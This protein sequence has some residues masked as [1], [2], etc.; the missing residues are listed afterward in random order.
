NEG[1]S[2]K[3]VDLNR[4]YPVDFGGS[5]SSSST[6]S[7]VYH[8]VAPFSEP[9]TQNINEFVKKHDN[10]KTM[11]SFHTYSELILYPWSYTY[12]P[13]GGLDEKVFAKM[14]KDMAEWN[15]YTPMQSSGLYTSSGDTC[16]WAY[17]EHEIFC[18]TFELNPSSA[19]EGGFYPGAE[20]IQ[21]AFQLNQK[22]VEYLLEYT[23]DPYRVLNRRR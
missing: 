21:K 2:C 22:P 23:D 3:G 13:I 9:E 20:M 16:D 15:N 18:F 4:N 19:G 5:G 1:S 14:A 17:K 10:I 8:G 11:I 6:C 12:D 7:D